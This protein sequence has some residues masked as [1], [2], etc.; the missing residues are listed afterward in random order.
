M[1]ELRKATHIAQHTAKWM[2]CSRNA[3]SRSQAWHWWTKMAWS[4]SLTTIS[5]CYLLAAVHIAYMCYK[6]RLEKM[7]FSR[8]ILG[9]LQ[10]TWTPSCA[11]SMFGKNAYI[12]PTDKFMNELG[13][14]CAH[15]WVAVIAVMYVCGVSVS[16]AGSV[17]ALMPI[18]FSMLVSRNEWKYKTRSA[19]FDSQQSRRAHTHTRKPTC[20]IMQAYSYLILFSNAILA[21]G[22][23]AGT[24]FTG[25]GARFQ[26]PLMLINSYFCYWNICC[27][28]WKS[29]MLDG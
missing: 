23:D 2:R 12:V 14:L 27:C 18:V 28:A 26:R 20:S 25:L 21:I 24:H 16:V 15:L 22:N 17:V 3:H 9:F 11:R 1:D 19:P 8:A 29:S 10:W 7:P 13:S 5:S 6:L 4:S